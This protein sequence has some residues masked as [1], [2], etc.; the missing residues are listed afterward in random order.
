MRTWNCIGIIAIV[1]V[2]G[3]FIKKHFDT[4][5]TCLA[6]TKPKTDSTPARHA[7]KFT[8]EYERLGGAPFCGDTNGVLYAI[9][10]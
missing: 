10:K 9:K 1:L 6:M 5:N 3:F 8:G 7:A 2:S 4:Y